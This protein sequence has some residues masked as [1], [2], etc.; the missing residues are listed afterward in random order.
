[1]KNKNQIPQE[2]Q[3]KAMFQHSQQP[4]LQMTIHLKRCPMMVRKIAQT[5]RTHN[6]C[7]N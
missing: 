2:L 7:I 1:M 4:K 3:V 5:P 6:M